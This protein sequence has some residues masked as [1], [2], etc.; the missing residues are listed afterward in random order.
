MATKE[1]RY[2]RSSENAAWFL[3]CSE[4]GWPLAMAYDEE[5]ASQIIADH[6]EVLSGERKI[7]DYNT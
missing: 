3:V 1:W 6:N 7:N 2:E 4:D 5:T